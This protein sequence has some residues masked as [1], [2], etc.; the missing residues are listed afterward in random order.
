MLNGKFGSDIRGEFTFISKQHSSVIDYTLASEGLLK[1][2]IDFRIGVEVISTHMPL[3]IELDNIIQGGSSQ[4]NRV[5]HTQSQELTRFKWNEKYE[6]VFIR[7]R[8]RR[9]IFFGGGFKIALQ[10]VR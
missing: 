7:R 6:S 4:I 8:I 10:K 3:V 5:S 2:I 9:E 1:H